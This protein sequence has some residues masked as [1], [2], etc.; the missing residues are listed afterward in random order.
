MLLLLLLISLPFF[1][2]GLIWYVAATTFAADRADARTVILA[3]GLVF[4]LL[5]GTF[6]FVMALL[7]NVIPL[8]PPLVAMIDTPAVLFVGGVALGTLGGTGF[9]IGRAHV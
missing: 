8:P 7:G 5:L 1:T 4:G 2:S 9:Q 6:L 3:Q